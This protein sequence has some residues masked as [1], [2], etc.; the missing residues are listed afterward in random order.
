MEVFRRF[1]FESCHSLPNVAEGH[2]CRRLHG[3]SYK[4]IVGVEGDVD[5][6]TGFV[7]DFGE[8]KKCVQPLVEELDHQL[9]N[10]TIAN[11]TAENVAVWFWERIDLPLSYVEVWETE[12]AG[13]RFRG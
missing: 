12:H 1:T 4:L 13:C 3:H 11:P 10:D 6:A 5:P 7:I 8:I 9:L 2:K